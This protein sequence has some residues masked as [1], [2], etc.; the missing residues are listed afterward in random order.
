MFNL[1]LDAFAQ[2]VELGFQRVV[3]G[4]VGNEDLYDVGFGIAGHAAELVGVDGYIARGQE[5][6]SH[7]YC[8]TFDEVENHLAG[9]FVPFRQENQAG[10]ISAFLRHGDTL[11]QDELVG[12]LYHDAG[13]V[14]GLGV[15]AFGTAVHHVFEHLEPFFYKLM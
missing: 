3:G 12:N 4:L 9:F 7:G 11:E 13:T 5:R 10:A 14:A 2:Y 6:Q 8:L 15:G 1:F